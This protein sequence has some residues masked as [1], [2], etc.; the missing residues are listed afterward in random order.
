M[1]D[2]YLSD[3]E[4][5]VIRTYLMPADLKGIDFWVAFEQGSE[6]PFML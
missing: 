3:D 4:D 1:I 2:S 5:R 6:V